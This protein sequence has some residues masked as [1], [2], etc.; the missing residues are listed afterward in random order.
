MSSLSPMPK[1]STEDPDDLPSVITRFEAR[2]AGLSSDQIR[3]RVRSGRW[4]PLAQGVY[5]RLPTPVHLDERTRAA[6]D[7][8]DLAYAAAMRH[9]GSAIALESAAVFHQLPLITPLPARPMLISSLGERHGDV[10]AHVHRRA[11]TERDIV[12]PAPG[13]WV[14]APARTWLDIS[15]RGHLPDSIAV[16]DA[17]LRAGL[18][19]MDDLVGI[20]RTVRGRHCRIIRRLTGLLDPRRE[21]ALESYSFARFVQWEIPIPE[22]QVEI[23]DRVGRFIGRVDFLWRSH[24][25]IGEADGALKYTA[26][27]VLYDEK[28]REDRLREQG[29]RVIRWG[30]DDLGRGGTLY[31]RLLSALAPPTPT[32]RVRAQAS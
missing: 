13:L 8:L 27:G 9:P 19:T 26:E 4:Q 24:G 6:Q 31:P 10:M 11:V 14:T 3:Q 23:S 5:R 15:R 30:W 2:A 1:L 21:T 28:R 25:L 29:Y 18:M 12:N 20:R 7:H 16:G 22:V 32:R 17:A